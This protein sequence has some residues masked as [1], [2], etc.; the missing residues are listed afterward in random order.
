MT[1]PLFDAH[2]HLGPSDTGEL[3]YGRLLGDELIELCDQAGVEKAL[4]FPPL[5]KTGYHEANLALADW[6][7]K[8]QR[9][10]RA[11]ARVGGRKIGWTEPVPWLL[12]RKLRRLVTNR[13]P[14]LLIEELPRFAGIKLLPHLDG[15][16][17]REF[18]EALNTLELPVLTH[19]GRFVPASFIESDILPLCNG[20]LIIAHLGAFPDIEADLRGAV[21][22][23]GRH[24]RVFL[25][26]SGIWIADFMRYAV[27]KVPEKL[28]WGSDCPLT[29]PRVAWDFIRSVVK[30]DDLLERIGY[31]TATQ[32][33]G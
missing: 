11:L 30:K 31:R 10:M 25:D 7:D 19:G 21:E 12:R 28:I 1:L 29:H 33:Y 24:E 18:F 3:Y 16:P 14:D 32:V 13:P 26:T 23:A 4:V 6:C 22:L 15:I 2:I 27:D 9:G 20:P 5:L 8:N 17:S